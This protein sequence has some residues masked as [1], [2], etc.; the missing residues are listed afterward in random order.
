MCTACIKYYCETGELF[1]FDK[2]LEGGSAP[3]ATE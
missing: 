2:F 3:P 1:D